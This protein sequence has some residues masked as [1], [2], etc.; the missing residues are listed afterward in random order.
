MFGQYGH[1]AFIFLLKLRTW[2]I[3]ISRSPCKNIVISGNQIG[4]LIVHEIHFGGA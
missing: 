2:E 4:V 1:S 3:L